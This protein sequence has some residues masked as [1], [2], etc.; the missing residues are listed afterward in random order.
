MSLLVCQLCI[1]NNKD[2][3]YIYLVKISFVKENI[4]LGHIYKLVHLAKNADPDM[5]KKTVIQWDL[6][7]FPMM[8]NNFHSPKYGICTL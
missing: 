2:Y 5:L 3:G 8:K 1:I 4:P 7:L 6:Y